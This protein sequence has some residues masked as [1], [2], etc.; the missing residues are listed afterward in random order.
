[1]ATMGMEHANF[2]RDVLAINKK[3]F[4]ARAA[5]PIRSVSRADDLEDVGGAHAQGAPGPLG[6]DSLGE[7]LTIA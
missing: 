2:M 6:C 7:Q 4:L 3:L 5:P 1:M